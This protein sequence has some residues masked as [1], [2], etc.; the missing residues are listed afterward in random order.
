VPRDVGRGVLAGLVQSG[1][2]FDAVA[3]LCE[4]A[5]RCDPALARLAATGGDAPLAIAACYPRAVRGLFQAA[6]HP[7]PGAGTRILNMRTESAEHVLAAVLDPGAPPGPGG[8]SDRPDGD[9]DPAPGPA[10]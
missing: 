1:R 5:A 9:L 10:E 6:G 3:D 4:L 7:L 2:S 8:G